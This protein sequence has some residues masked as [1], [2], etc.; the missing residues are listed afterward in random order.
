MIV[1]CLGGRGGVRWSIEMGNFFF[2]IVVL[3][4]VLGFVNFGAKIT[5]K[6]FEGGL[7][8]ISSVMKF[9]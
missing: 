4:I 1:Y 7:D 2:K 5:H 6:V 3:C 9:K 8:F